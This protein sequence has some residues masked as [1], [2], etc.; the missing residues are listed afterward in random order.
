MHAFWAW[1]DKTWK[2]L[3]SVKLTLVVFVAMLLLAIPGTLFLQFNIS[4]VDPGI[5]YDYDFWKF[6]QFIQLFSAYHSFWYTGL[7]VLLAM[8]LIACSVERW[9]QMLKL[10]TAKPVKWS[11]ETFNQQPEEQH[12]RWKTS[13]AKKT[14]LKRIEAKIKSPFVRPV[15]LEDK[16]NSFQVFWQEGRWSR[17]AN[18]LVHTSLLVVFLGAIVAAMYGFEGAANI[19]AGSAVDTFLIFNEG[20]GSGLRPAPGGLINERLMGFRIEA[21]EFDVKFY[22]DFP[23]RPKD[24]VS[25]LNIIEDE[26]IVKSKV[27]RVNDPLEYKNFVIYQASYGRMGD[28][29]IR[30]RILNKS[31][32]E[33]PQIYVRSKLGEIQ[34]VAQ[35]KINIVPLRAALDVQNLGPGVQFQEVK[36][37]Q[38]F[39]EPFWVLKDYPNFDLM[40]R[41]NS[42]YGVVVDD[43]KEQYFTGL[44]IGHDPGAPIYWLGAAGM[45]IGTFY[46]LFMTHRKYYLNYENGEILFAGTVNRL[47]MGFESRVRKIADQMRNLSKG[48]PYVDRPKNS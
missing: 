38:A 46:A 10:A 27:I 26:K 29:D 5:Q 47:P 31:R 41:K 21:E 4:N 11:R 37:G 34:N 36:K 20:K 35:F 48:D 13:L 7:I 15:I 33:D 3:A 44:Q 43:L 22:D 19:P 23:G 2:A 25:K 45:L 18:Y 39:G 1:V 24:F 16:E 12:Y 8:N 30:F 9:P 40:R 42:T 6:G 14:L 32:P 28:F 17:V